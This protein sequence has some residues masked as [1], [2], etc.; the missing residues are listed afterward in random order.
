MRI[1]LEKKNQ[2]EMKTEYS[3]LAGLVKEM[4]EKM[5]FN[6]FLGI[7]IVSYDP[8]SVSLTF[9]MKDVFV[10]N[11]VSKTLH[12]GVIA[13]VLDLTGGL[14]ASMGIIKKFE[15]LPLEEIEKWFSKG[16]GG[17][18]DLRVDYLMRGQGKRFLSKGSVVR[19]GKKVIVTRMEL[20]N[21][22]EELLAIATGTYLNH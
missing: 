2:V 11:P 16:D 19:L 15:G 6:A 18:I 5:P 9:E 8:A 4:W 12:G 3:R 21:D 14:A 20:H 10:G 1:G 13:S 17:T 22:K 7:R